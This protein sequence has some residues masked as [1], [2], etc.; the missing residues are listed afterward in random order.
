MT[1]SFLAPPQLTT[2]P[3][4][5]TV[6]VLAATLREVLEYLETL[7]RHLT[8]DVIHLKQGSATFN[9]SNLVDGAGETTTVAVTGALLGDLAFASFSLDLQGITVTPYVSASDVVSVRFQNETGGTINLAS[10]TLRA[11]TLRLSEV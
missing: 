7:R 9:P 1:Y 10:G 4:T 8:I 6:P 2:R 3:G 11:A 5:E